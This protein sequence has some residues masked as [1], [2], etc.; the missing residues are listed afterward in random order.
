MTSTRRKLLW[1]A[2]FAG[3]TLIFFSENIWGY[4]RFRQ[5]CAE[6]AGIRVYEPV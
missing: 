2:F 1:L 6:Q 4:F 3:I 5:I